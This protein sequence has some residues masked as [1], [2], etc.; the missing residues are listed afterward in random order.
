M[1]INVIEINRYAPLPYVF[2]EAARF[3]RDSIRLAGFASDHLVH[4]VEPGVLSIVLGGHPD[5]TLLHG[6]P[7]DELIVFNFEQLGSNSALVTPRYLD[8]LKA[9]VVFDYHA[10]N[11]AHLVAQG[12]NPQRCHEMPIQ[13]V[14]GHFNPAWHHITKTCD[15]SFCGSMSPRRKAIVEQ[16]QAHGLTVE[17]PRAAYG[18]SL[19][20]ALLRARLV[21]N[22]HYYETRLFPVLRVARPVLLGLPVV[23]ET[24]EHSPLS[25]W[26]QSGVV[27]ADYDH[28]VATC[29]DVLAFPQRQQDSIARSWRFVQQLPFA[30]AFTR[31]LQPWLSTAATG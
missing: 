15:V 7:A 21:L 4:R 27:F 23:S 2:S 3:L 6:I 29:L 11:I 16:L 1:K 24:S 31:A 30:A 25:D 17:L 18:D 26:S 22:I 19:V 9:H 13:P 10:S 8:W 12:A 14:A 5:E 28:L 20:P